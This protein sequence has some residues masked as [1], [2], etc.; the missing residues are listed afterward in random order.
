M[1]NPAFASG[2]FVGLHF[3]LALAAVIILIKAIE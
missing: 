2:F 1:L 3:G